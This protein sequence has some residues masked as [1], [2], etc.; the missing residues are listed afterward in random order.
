MHFHSK[1]ANI[2]D[3]EGEVAFFNAKCR[4]HRNRADLR[5]FLEESCTRVPKRSRNFVCASDRSG[6]D[7]QALFI[8]WKSKLQ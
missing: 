2:N 6:K 7:S 8:P 5:P 4:D 3:D 1:L